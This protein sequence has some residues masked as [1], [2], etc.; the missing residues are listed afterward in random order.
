MTVFVLILLHCGTSS[1]YNSTRRCSL[2][3][4]RVHE[5]KHMYLA[6]RIHGLFI[7]LTQF[8]ISTTYTQ[9]AQ[10]VQGWHYTGGTWCNP[11]YNPP[12]PGKSL[13]CSWTPLTYLESLLCVWCDSRPLWSQVACVLTFPPP[14]LPI[15]FSLS[16]TVPHLKYMPS[17]DNITTS[18]SHSPM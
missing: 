8:F 1:N 7:T 5:I 16:P 3:L 17:Y 6:S 15:P 12:L 4:W 11:L 9:L 14:F 10:Y 13:P 18:A 2:P